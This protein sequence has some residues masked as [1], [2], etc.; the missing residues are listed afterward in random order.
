MPECQAL[1]ARPLVRVPAI[2]DLGL[3]AV[4]VDGEPLAT[5]TPGGKLFQTHRAPR[6]P[7]QGEL[8]TAPRTLDGQQTD[9]VAR[10]LAGYRLAGDERNPLRGDVIAV[11]RF[12]FA[13]TP[14]HPS[15]A[16]AGPV[17]ARPS[18]AASPG[19]IGGRTVKPFPLRFPRARPI[20]PPPPRVVPLL[21]PAVPAELTGGDGRAIFAPR[22]PTAAG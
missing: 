12:V 16:W 3:T 5:A 19:S 17:S 20:R 15:I 2:V 8:W 6:K 18:S 9:P 14:P 4:E 10:T 7:I 11:A 21:Q 13:V 22:G 1:Q